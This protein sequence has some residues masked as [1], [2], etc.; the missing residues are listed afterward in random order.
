MDSGSISR[1]PV[2]P[3]PPSASR[4]LAAVG[5]DPIN[6]HRALGHAPALL[7]PVLDLI[8][9]LR[10]DAKVA[11]SLRELMICRIAQLEDSDYELAHHLP[12]AAESGLD[13]D[14]VASIA[15]WREAA[16]FDERQRA[17]LGY[18]EHLGAGAD[19]DDEALDKCFDPVEQ[20]ELTVTGAT[21]IALA[22]MLR[23]LDV[24]IDASPLD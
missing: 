8:H 16:C 24:R 12:M 11:R 6:L 9:A 13:E 4:R 23:A 15:G 7:A 22:R 17:V 20:T 18:A 3:L 10:F 19:R 14:Q 5:R 21:Y 2:A 1:L